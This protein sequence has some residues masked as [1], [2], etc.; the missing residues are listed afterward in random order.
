MTKT[1]NI[2]ETPTKQPWLLSSLIHCI[3]TKRSYYTGGAGTSYLYIL[4]WYSDMKGT[5]DHDIDDDDDGS[6][7]AKTLQRHTH[8]GGFSCCPPV[9]YAHKNGSQ[10][11]SSEIRVKGESSRKL[12]CHL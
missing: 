6:C 5:C 11:E 8:I 9:L 3:S 12:Y 2:G 1:E 10:K 7:V 4:L